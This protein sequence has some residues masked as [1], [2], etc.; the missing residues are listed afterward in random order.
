MKHQNNA[1]LKLYV[2]LAS[3]IIPS[4]HLG[5][6]NPQKSNKLEI[7]FDINTC[8]KQRHCG[9][10]TEGGAQGNGRDRFM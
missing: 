1:N 4:S 6:Y 7:K 9:G 3:L 2:D 8:C 5:Q 10:V